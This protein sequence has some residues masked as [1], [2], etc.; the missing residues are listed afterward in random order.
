MNIAIPMN[1][2][3][4][5][6]KDLSERVSQT[7]KLLNEHV[8]TLKKLV[9]AKKAERDELIALCDEEIA[10]LEV[11]L[12][13]FGVKSQAE[14]PSDTTIRA[15]NFL[16]ENAG[17]EFGGTEIMKAIHAEGAVASIVL[18][19]MSQSGKVTKIGMYKGCKYLV[20]HLSA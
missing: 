1:G 13:A 17:Q 5:D 9:A 20:E 16:K 10:G 8:D 3:T 12:S 19:P 6:D 11:E 2:F 18:A 7:R 4:I 15:Y 14:R